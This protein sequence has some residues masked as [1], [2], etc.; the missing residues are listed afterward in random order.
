MTSDTS[1]PEPADD[2]RRRPRRRGEELYAAIFEATLAELEEVGYARLTIERVAAR[3]RASK[4]SVYKR[5]PNRRELVIAALRQQDRTPEPAIDTGTLRGDLL[6][7]LRG[8]AAQLEG[9]LGEAVRGL[10]AETLMEPATTAE[11]RAEAFA[12]RDLVVRGFFERAA[13]RGEINTAA[14]SAQLVNLGPALLDHHLL[15]HGLPIP[16]DLI[17]GVVDDILLPLLTSKPAGK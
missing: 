16:D 6:A 5:W 14:I 8:A 13:A 11:A 7:F 10:M 3:A 4:M 17:V 9:M 12:G 15:V 1:R 2:F